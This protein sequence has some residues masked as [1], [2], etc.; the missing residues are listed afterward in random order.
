MNPA[1]GQVLTEK[2][3]GEGME[4]GTKNT[5]QLGKQNINENLETGQKNSQ[6]ANNRPA[7]ARLL[8]ARTT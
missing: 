1:K 7:A 5:E 6:N 4:K 8:A 2:N 3:L